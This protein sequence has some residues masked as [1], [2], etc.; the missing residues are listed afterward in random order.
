MSRDIRGIIFFGKRFVSK[1]KPIRDDDQPAPASLSGG[2]S[3]VEHLQGLAKQTTG[4]KGERTKAHLVASTAQYL[5]KHGLKGLT[6]SHLYGAAGI[7]VAT[8]YLYFKNKADIVNHVIELFIAFVPQVDNP[9][10]QELRQLGRA[11]DDPYG[12]FYISTLQLL[13]LAEANSGMF[14]CVLQSG[15]EHDDIA[16]RWL[17]FSAEFWE[18][19]ARRAL[20]AAPDQP[21]EELRLKALLLSGMVEDFYKNYFVF[22]HATYKAAWDNHYQSKV[23]IAMFL[24]DLWYQTMMNKAPPSDRRRWLDISG[25]LRETSPWKLERKSS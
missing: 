4:R 12:S 16:K 21:L 13:H 2:Y 15:A 1:R 10:Q 19:G 22:E 17:D 6:L 23:E 8:F 9:A 11:D 5:E 20:R 18:R 7:N 3:F 25:E 14:R 24:A